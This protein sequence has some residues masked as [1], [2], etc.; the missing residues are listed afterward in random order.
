MQNRV[1]YRSGENLPFIPLAFVFCLRPAGQARPRH[2]PITETSNQQE[3]RGFLD[4]LSFIAV[5]GEDVKC[6]A[7]IQR[8]AQ[9][10]DKH[11]NH[12]NQNKFPQQSNLLLWEAFLPGGEKDS[13][14]NIWPQRQ[15]PRKPSFQE[16]LDEEKKRLEKVE[17]GQ[18]LRKR[19]EVLGAMG[20]WELEDLLADLCEPSFSRRQN[21]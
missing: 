19:G 18:E 13:E 3:G 8:G 5:V 12:A 2:H 15:G 6:M 7:H 17:Q 4:P 11:P 10:H 14:K 16:L 1:H 9:E 21:E 20:E